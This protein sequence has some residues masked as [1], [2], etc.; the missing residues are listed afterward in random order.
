MRE[1]RRARDE[2]GRARE[3]QQRRLRHPRTSSGIAAIASRNSAAHSP[4]PKCPNAASIAATTSILGSIVS[5]LLLDLRRRLHDRDRRADRRGDEQDRQRDQRGDEQRVTQQSVKA[6]H[7]RMF[8]RGC[9]GAV[10]ASS[11]S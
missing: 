7:P 5:V 4:K 9:Y 6:L 10:T 2:P 11:T 1:A 8:A 3:H